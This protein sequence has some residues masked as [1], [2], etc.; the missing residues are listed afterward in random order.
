MVCLILNSIRDSRHTYY[1]IAIYYICS[2]LYLFFLR[3]LF[4]YV[5]IDEAA[6]SNPLDLLIPMSL[7]RKIIL[8]GDHKQ[9]PHMVEP[10]IVN[11]VV[12]KTNKED[13]KQVLEESL[14]MRLFNKVSAADEKARLDVNNPML[15]TRTC[16]LNE[17]FRMHSAICDLI[18]V[19]YQEEH[20]RPAC[21]VGK[22]DEF[23]KKKEHNLSL[24][25][26]KPLC[27]LDVPIN[28]CYPMETGGISKS[29]PC[30]VEIIK[31]E[32][33]KILS[34]NSEFT[35]GIITFYSKQA[36]LIKNMIENEFPSEMHRVSVGTV[37]AFQG[38]EFDIVFLSAVRA[39]NEQEMKRRVGFL[40]NN[41][42]L[43]VAFS[44]AKRLL[45]AVGD[46]QTVAQNGDEAIIEP[47][48]ELLDRCKQGEVG[49]YENSR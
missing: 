6:R 32:L 29:R 21:E 25:N 37:D 44:R 39:N 48:K 2:P 16:V 9:L 15:V 38:K 12:E 36:A 47:L 19:F 28:D 33:N 22:V 1:I 43:C 40:N 35:I 23:N 5:I 8:V 10:E 7:G 34:L 45:I 31:Q 14:F 30:E 3:F 24:Y 20:L 18:N 41:N 11:A 49:Y 13:A 4:I 26:N 42:R 27:W 46:S 17:Q